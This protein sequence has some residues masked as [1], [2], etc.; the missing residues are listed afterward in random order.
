MDMG[1]QELRDGIRAEVRRIPIKEDCE[2]W[3]LEAYRQTID[4]LLKA[5]IQIM[6]AM[7]HSYHL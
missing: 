3:Q 2:V 4:A 1:L 5:E 7:K 6:K